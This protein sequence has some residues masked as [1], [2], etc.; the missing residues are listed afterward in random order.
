MEDKS[1]AALA[2]EH[3]ALTIAEL[4]RALAGAQF[5]AHQ[6][7][8]TVAAQATIIQSQAGQIKA[9]TAALEGRVASQALPEWMPIETAPQDGYMLVHEDGA[10]RAMFRSMGKWQHVA[11]PAIVDQWDVAIVGEDARRLLPAC[12]RLELRDGCCTAPTHWMTMPAAPVA[13]PTDTS[14]R[15]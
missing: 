6:H 2:M 5:A 11:Y 12:C 3:A 14:K 1:K 9:L 10:I 13:Q 4:T 15:A 8:M 7:S